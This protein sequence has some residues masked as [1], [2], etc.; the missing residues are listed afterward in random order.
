MNPSFRIRAL[1]RE[2][3]E[4]LLSMDDREL[5]ARGARWVTVTEAPGF[6]CRVS[7]KDIPVGERV[8]LTP[9]IHHDVDSPYRASGPIFV[10]DRAEPVVPEV[11]E[12]PHLLLHRTLSLRAY[13][14]DGTMRDAA[15]CQ[16]GEVAAT[17]GRMFLDDRIAYLHVHNAGAGCFNCRVDR[18]GA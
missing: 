18:A 12:V 4:H 16:G 17:I 11:N 13:D 1:P 15:L 3:F 14:G 10:H 9:Y 5:A 2:H 7:L 6:P 8:L